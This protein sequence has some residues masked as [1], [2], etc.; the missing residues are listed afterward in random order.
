MFIMVPSSATSPG[1]AMRPHANLER[2]EA[3][4]GQEE[5]REAFAHLQDP[6]K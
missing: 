2:K 4:G 5:L 3:E 6:K 1:R